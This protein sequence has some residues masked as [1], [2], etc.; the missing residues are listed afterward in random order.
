LKNQELRYYCD[1]TFNSDDNEK[2]D[3]LLDYAFE[4]A[5]FVEFNIFYSNQELTPEI[6]A[7][8]SD[9]VGKGRR[10]NKKYVSGDYLR[11]RMSDKLK[12]FIKSKKYKDWNNYNLEDISFLK[13]DNEFL[14]TIT[15]E[16]YIIIQTTEKQREVLNENGFNFLCDWGV[17]LI[18]EKARHESCG[19]I[20]KI[21]DLLTKS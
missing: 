14:A 19:L 6:D 20:K 21:K 2:W 5:D 13:D 1:D 17:D 3:F 8:D 12:R 16:N 18:N 7:L 9:L 15:H 10:K 11:C 4:R